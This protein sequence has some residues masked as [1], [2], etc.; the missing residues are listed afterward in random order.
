MEVRLSESDGEV[1]GL[2]SIAHMF[3]LAYRCWI[4]TVQF[5]GWLQIPHQSIVAKYEN[6]HGDWLSALQYMWRYITVIEVVNNG[7]AGLRASAPNTY[8]LPT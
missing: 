4:F 3:L 5:D 1:S 7:G 2:S 6:V 8:L